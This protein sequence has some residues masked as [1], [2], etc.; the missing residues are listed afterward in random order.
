MS[1]PTQMRSNR[2]PAVLLAVILIGG[3]LFLVAKALRGTAPVHDATV[4]GTVTIDGQLAN[5]G[6]VT[7]HPASG[8]QPAT[9]TVHTDGSYSLRSGQGDLKDIDG[10]TIASGGYV[11]TVSINAPS[12]DGETSPEGGPPRPGPSLIDARYTKTDTSELKHVVEPGRNVIVLNLDGPTEEAAE[13]E[14]T[15]EVAAGEENPTENSSEESTSA[16]NNPAQI[17]TDI[18]AA[19]PDSQEDAQ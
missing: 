12:P 1:E 15:D 11:V 9:G 18:E 16:H 19:H 7:F 5:S 2:L 6:T 8:G 17:E 13:E 14:S 3:G 10:G 4:T